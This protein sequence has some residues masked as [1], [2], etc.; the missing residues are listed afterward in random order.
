VGCPELD[1]SGA[2]KALVALKI[3]LYCD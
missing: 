2:S 3:N 1:G